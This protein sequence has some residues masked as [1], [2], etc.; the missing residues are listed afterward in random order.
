M[1]ITLVRITEDPEALI[2]SAY[3]I[4]YA[5][6]KSLNEEG[7]R[8]FIEDCISSGHE[9]PLE[10]AVATF[11]FTDVTRSLL[12]QL[13][14]HRLVSYSVQSQRYVDARKFSY[15]IPDSVSENPLAL[16]LY[17]TQVENQFH[18]YT[19]L[20]ELKIPKE[21]ARMVL[22]ESTTTEI[23]MTANFREYRHII[24]IRGLNRHAQWEIR[25]LALAI[26]DILYSKAP[27]IFEDLYERSHSNPESSL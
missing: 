1:N 8:E 7:R 2:E 15:I 16:E 14:R 18:L 5:S 3:R 17:K 20:R 23:L 4:C 10:H 12:A 6:K 11:K 26:L 13:T 27:S 19:K 9:S 24:K 25:T 22:S 21:D